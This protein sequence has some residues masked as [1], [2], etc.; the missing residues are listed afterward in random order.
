LDC[1]CCDSSPNDTVRKPFRLIMTWNESIDFGNLPPSK[2]RSSVAISS[3]ELN[4]IIGSVQNS[5][6]VV[7]ARVIR[8][9]LLLLSS[10]VFPAPCLVPIWCRRRRRHLF[11]FV[12]LGTTG[13]TGSL[14]V[15]KFFSLSR[16]MNTWCTIE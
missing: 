3:R 1:C 16:G 15:E 2:T 4:N 14:Y 8:Y 13:S 7:Q 10:S 9:V 5:N 6:R 12:V 11:W